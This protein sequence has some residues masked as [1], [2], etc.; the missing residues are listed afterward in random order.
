MLKASH[1]QVVVL[2]WSYAAGNSNK[3]AFFDGLQIC[4]GTVRTGAM[5]AGMWQDGVVIV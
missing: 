3:L 1:M 2:R 5:Y 4:D